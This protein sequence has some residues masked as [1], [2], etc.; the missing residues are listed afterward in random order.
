M[1]SQILHFGVAEYRLARKSPWRAA[2]TGGLPGAI[3]AT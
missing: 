2:A 1:I 3:V